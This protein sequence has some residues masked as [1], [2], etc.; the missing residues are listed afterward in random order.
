MTIRPAKAMI[1]AAGLGLRMR[2][3][4]DTTP[5]PLLE[6]C[7]RTLLDHE[8][9]RLGAAGVRDVVVN[10]HWKAEQIDAY[11][12]R[13][14]AAGMP[15]RTMLM[16]EAA[17]LDTGGSVQAALPKLGPEPFY[18]INGDAFWQDGPRP[19]LARLARA[20]DPAEMDGVLLVHRSFQVRAEVGYGD[21]A[22]DK[23]GLPSRRGERQVVPYIFAGVQL[24]APALLDGMPNGMAGEMPVGMGHK[25]SMNLAWDRAIAAGRLRVVVHD[26][27]WFHLSTPEDLR[28][29]EQMLHPSGHGEPR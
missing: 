2:P 6:L 29:A 11:L 9:E 27:L 8:F 24:I 4:T 14:Q 17:L 12:A 22:V 1:L 3:L 23:L 5:K 20:F 16:R 15:I 18:V 13:R 28:D 26:G 7:G 21:F 25:F 19:A 10:A